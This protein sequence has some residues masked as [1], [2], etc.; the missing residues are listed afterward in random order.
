MA[1][2]LGACSTEPSER[3]IRAL[4]ADGYDP[5]L[6]LSATLTCDHTL[7]HV[8]L[9][10]DDEGSFELSTNVQD[11]CTRAGGGFD[12]AEVFRIGSYTRLGPTLSFTSEGRPAPEFTGR[13]EPGRLVL[14]FTP[15]LDSLASDVEVP[16]KQSQEF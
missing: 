16:V 11:D 9:E 3:L 2:A 6:V 15:G 1:L 5:P 8:L 4:Y 13:L 14:V 12:G 7:T 10:L